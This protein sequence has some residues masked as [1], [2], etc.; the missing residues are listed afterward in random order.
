MMTLVFVGNLG[1]IGGATREGQEKAFV[2]LN[3]GRSATGLP[4]V[5]GAR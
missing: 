4:G 3:V 5:I 2:F 1:D